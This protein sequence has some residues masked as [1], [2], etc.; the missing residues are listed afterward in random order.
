[1][2]IVK[3]YGGLGNQLFQYA[4]AK[5]IGLKFTHEVFIDKSWYDNIPNSNTKRIY[6]LDKFNVNERYSNISNG[7]FIS[8]VSP[9]IYSKG[10]LLWSINER[11]FNKISNNGHYILNDYWQSTDYFIEN[12]QYILNSLKVNYLYDYSI[13]VLLEE[14][15]KNNSVAIHVRRGDYL[16]NKSAALKHGVCSLEYYRLAIKT[17]NSFV[18]NPCFYIF[19][20]EISWAKENFKFI[21]NKYFIDDDY[22]DTPITDFLLMSNCKHHIIANSSFSWWGAWIAWSSNTSGS[23]NI[24]IAPKKWFLDGE[25]KKNLFPGDWMII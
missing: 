13:K 5:N 2:I 18:K 3:I 24:V 4:A 10:K 22:Q 15:K 19:S 14:I 8:K 12:N 6:L 21:D 1:M 23:K 17:I 16:T 11:N 25:T 20:D 7:T 9:F